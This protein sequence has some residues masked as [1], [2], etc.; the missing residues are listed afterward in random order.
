MRLSG[1]RSRA[2]VGLLLMPMVLPFPTA[3]RPA[4]RG[5]LVRRASEEEEFQRLRPSGQRDGLNKALS[6]IYDSIFFSGMDLKE[7]TYRGMDFSEVMEN[8]QI[9]MTTGKPY[10]RKPRRDAQGVPYPAE[11]KPDSWTTEWRGSSGMSEEE[12]QW[13]L[14][15]RELEE[16]RQVLT[17]IEDEIDAKAV[18]IELLESRGA[19]VDDKGRL[20][21]EELGIEIED[22]QDMQRKAF[23]RYLAATREEKALRPEDADFEYDGRN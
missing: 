7:D 13:G 20:R 16:A 22:L 2:C 11:E 4:R 18:S 6:R 1:V 5:I 10:Q 19:D 17:E 8:L 12:R 21:L 14:A 9:G 15:Q 23:Q 3:L